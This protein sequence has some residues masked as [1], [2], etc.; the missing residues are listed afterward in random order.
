MR[1]L[2]LVSDAHGGRGGIAQYNRDVIAALSANDRISEIIVLPR[3]AEPSDYNLPPKV[4]YDLRAT[5]GQLAFIRRALAAAAKAGPIDVVF[6]GH[7]NLMPVAAMAKWITRGKLVLAVHGTD[8]WEPSASFAARVALGAADSIF[9]VSQF[10]LDKMSRWHGAAQHKG[11]VIP[12]TFRPEGYGMAPPNA[13]LAARLGLTGKRV[14]MTLGRM[15]SDER[16]KGFDE[17]IELMPALLA[18]CPQLAYLCAGDGDD[19]ARLEEKAAEL[20]LSKS[21]IFAGAVPEEEKPDYYRL[22]DAFVLAS[23]GEGFGIVLLEAMACGIPVVGST[24]DATQEALLH[25]ELGQSVDPKDGAAL[26]DAILAAIDRP[27]IVP[28]KLNIFGFERFSA[29]IGAGIAALV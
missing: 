12:N 15:A 3:L 10:T 20:G 6:C 8:V 2:M 14:I 1:V 25:G 21:V 24:A 23:R 9:S 19:R 13:D 5:G 28:A 29:Q 11:R 22:A 4:R 16:A 26:A 7:I 27:K 17:V 18:R